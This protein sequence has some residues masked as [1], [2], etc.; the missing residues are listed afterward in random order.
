MIRRQSTWELQ[1]FK[2]RWNQARLCLRTSISG[3]SWG[4]TCSQFFFSMVHVCADKMS[5]ELVFLLLDVITDG[6]FARRTKDF[7]VLLDLD[8][9]EE[10]TK[11][12]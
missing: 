7:H 10:N 3:S 9:Y 4:L 1:I 8:L 5:S 2:D 12:P 6:L 11:L